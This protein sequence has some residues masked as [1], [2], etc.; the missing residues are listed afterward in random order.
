M[1]LSGSANYSRLETTSEITDNTTRT[2]AGTSASLRVRSF[3]LSGSARLAETATNPLDTLGLGLTN[4]SSSTISWNTAADY[5]INLIGSTTL[6]PTAGIS[7][8]LFRSFD[9]SNDYVSTPTRLNFGATLSTDVFGFWPGFGPFS[10]VRHKLSPQMSWA[11]SPETQLNPAL[12]GIPGL[13][14]GSA[15]ARNTLNV[16]FRQTFEAKVK[17]VE[18]AGSG[19]ASGRAIAARMAAADTAAAWI[20]L[21]AGAPS[22]P[23]D[24]LRTSPGFGS[25]VS[26]TLRGPAAV[27][28]QERTATLLAINTSGLSWDFERAKSGL[29]TLITEQLTNGLTSDLLRG[30]TV[31]MTHDL[32]KGQGA[33]REFS[34]SLARLAMSFSLQSGTGIGD[35][36]GLGRT[37]ARVDPMDEQRQRLDSRG[38]LMSFD[39]GRTDDPF[40]GGGAAGPWSLNLRYSL[41]RVRA[42]EPGSDSQTIDGTLSFHP[43]SKWAIRWSTQYSF[44]NE[45]FGAQLI[46]LDRDLHRWRASFQFS[47][48]PNGNVIFQVLLTLTDAPDLKVTY[49]QKSEPP[50]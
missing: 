11:Y 46:T 22:V 41:L 49:D 7:G 16:A 37:G 10:R 15:A 23:V 48:A 40:A 6:R 35:L 26:D 17:P 21:M 39:P 25:V 24:R 28:R 18:P 33:D 36:V 45:E 27:P 34:P 30:F 29:P 50:S 13:P 12:E 3:N 32:F 47:R 42:G 19:R 38:R 44:T 5:Q 4:F 8:S 14:A 1:T 9:T 20:A 2:N 43:T 31:N